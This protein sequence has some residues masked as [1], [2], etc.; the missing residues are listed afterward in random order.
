LLPSYFF[1]NLY[2][3]KT[4]VLNTQKKQ[5][6]QSFI[7][8]SI[9]DIIIDTPTNNILNNS[10][11]ITPT[12]FAEQQLYQKNQ[13]LLLKKIDQQFRMETLA[14]KSFFYKNYDLF[15]YQSFV[16]FN[17]NLRLDEIFF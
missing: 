17:K 9:S 4:P 14:T 15:E 1:T 11:L 13:D 12:S 5:I 8:F 7:Y 16:P 6:N 3:S 2:F 10:S